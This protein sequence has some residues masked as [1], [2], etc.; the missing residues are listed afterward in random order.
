MPSAAKSVSHRKT[1]KPTLNRSTFTASGLLDFF[2]EKELTAQ[3]GHA[4]RDWPLVL[5]KKLLDNAIDACEEAGV[6]PM[7]TV[8]V[9][10]YGITVT[11]NGPGIPPDTVTA[12][13][14][15]SVRVSSREHYV[16]PTRGA[17]GN[18]LKTVV[19]MPFVL[20]GKSGRVEVNARGVRHEIDV[21]V[22]RIR[23]EPKIEHRQCPDRRF[24]KNGTSV[25]VHWPNSASPIRDSA[26]ARFL[27]IADDYAFL[28]PHLSLTLDWFGERTSTPAT[29]RTWS[30]FLPSHPTSSH[31]YT[32]ERFDRLIA[33]CLGDDETKGRDRTIREFVADFDGLSVSA[34]Q[35]LVLDAADLSRQSLSALRNGDG[36]K[37]DRVGQLLEAMR[38]HTRP[39]KPPALGVIG[40]EHLAERF[41]GLGCEMATFNY[42][43]LAGEQDGL[44][45]VVETAFA[46][47]KAAF[48]SEGGI[49]TRRRMVSGVNWSPAVGATPFRQ[50]GY[51]SLDSILEQQ[52]AGGSEPVVFLLHLACPR[53]NYTDRGKSAVV[54]EDVEKAEAVEESEEGDDPK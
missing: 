13:L 41:R 48:R 20:D 21:K 11:D 12:V 26:K 44:P 7:I 30:K 33:G 10:K 35:K 17:Q 8:I 28:N 54:I 27:Q 52:R 49:G 36:L 29:T 14:D 37:A 31:W 24:V 43:K 46:A 18:A 53:I 25:L 16:S 34:K 40:K 15:F 42:R 51:T 2:S 32:P 47:S 23:Q 39:I 22:D 45:H 4:K 3:T 1:A 19:A 50:L 9:D 6:A 5:L 38:Q